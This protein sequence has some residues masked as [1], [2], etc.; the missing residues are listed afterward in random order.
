[1]EKETQLR[2]INE[3]EK[4]K[5]SL[6]Q[7]QKDIEDNNLQGAGDCTCGATLMLQP[8]MTELSNLFNNK[9]IKTP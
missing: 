6:T 3:L 5:Q 1:M 9:K 7:A 4:V 2:L 8:I